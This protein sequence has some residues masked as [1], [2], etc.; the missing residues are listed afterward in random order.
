MSALIT[1][2][3][4]CPICNSKARREIDLIISARHTDNESGDAISVDYNRTL[5]DIGKLI[6]DL[7]TD[8]VITLPDLVV[9]T[10]HHSIITDIEKFTIRSEGSILFAGDKVF[11]KINPIDFLDFSLAVAAEKIA[12]GEIKLTPSFIINAII[13]RWRMTGTAGQDSL[14]EGLH[15]KITKQTISP[16]SPLGAAK[17]SRTAALEAIEPPVREE[18]EEDA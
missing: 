14:L 5:E 10:V 9:H 3:K 12:T 7:A 16:E 4:K 17:I 18:T 1:Q 6:V 2:S 8:D 15:D 11:Q 13:T